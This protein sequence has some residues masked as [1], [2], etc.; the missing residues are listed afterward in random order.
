MRESETYGLSREEG[1]A[2]IDHLVSAI[3]DNWDDA[4]E[5]ARLSAADKQNL[6]RK[7]ILPRAAFFDYWNPSH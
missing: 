1:R 5:V 7:Q 3:H 6:R 2:I 4:A